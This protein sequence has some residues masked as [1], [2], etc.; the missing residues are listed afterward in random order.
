[1]LT[2]VGKGP[3]KSGA[4]S[5]FFLLLLLCFVAADCRQPSKEEVR[6]STLDMRENKQCWHWHCKDDEEGPIEETV[7][8]RARYANGKGKQPCVAASLS[9][10][11]AQCYMYVNNKLE[12]CTGQKPQNSLDYLERSDFFAAPVVGA[13][14]CCLVSCLISCHSSVCPLQING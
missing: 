12:M 4:R 11:S 1:M 6:I 13:V 10:S 9:R 2:T 5:L 14:R 3:R 7:G 8:G